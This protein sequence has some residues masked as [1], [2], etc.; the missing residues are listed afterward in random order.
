M[1]IESTYILTIAKSLSAHFFGLVIILYSSGCQL[2]KVFE[3]SV[4][5]VQ[6]LVRKWI[7]NYI[8]HI[9]ASFLEK[10]ESLKHGQG[11]EQGT[12]TVPETNPASGQRA[13]TQTWDL[14]INQNTSL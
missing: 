13:R 5:A 1:Q 7:P 6:I 9:I 10:N 11:F 2:V 14:Q 4:K 3:F 8:S 12:C